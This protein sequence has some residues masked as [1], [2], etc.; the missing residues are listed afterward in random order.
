MSQAEIIGT[1][2]MIVVF[3]GLGVVGWIIG[4]LRRNRQEAGGG[5]WPW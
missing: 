3:L 2:M 1:I 4:I 5:S